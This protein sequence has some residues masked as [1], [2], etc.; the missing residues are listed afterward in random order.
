MRFRELPS[1]E[2]NNYFSFD[3][4]MSS[5]IASFSSQVQCCDRPQVM[6]YSR[7]CAHRSTSTWKL[8]D[9]IVAVRS[10]STTIH[11]DVDLYMDNDD[12]AL[13][14]QHIAGSWR[15]DSQTLRSLGCI[16]LVN[17][18]PR[19]QAHYLSACGHTWIDE[20]SGPCVLDIADFP[21]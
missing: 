20:T 13:Q 18:V 3:C 19:A 11:P 21:R 2:Y 17:F 7:H 1:G 12:K 8:I 14:L 15:R 5:I 4:T 16:F 10:V 9:I 6:V